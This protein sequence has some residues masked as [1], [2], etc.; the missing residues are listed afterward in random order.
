MP[1]LQL[2]PLLRSHFDALQ[3]RLACFCKYGC[4]L[5]GWFKGELLTVLDAALQAG[6]I[7]DVDREIATPAGKIDLRVTL[8]GEEPTW[9]ELKHWLIGVQRGTRYGAGFYFGDPTSVGITKDVKKLTDGERAGLGYVLVLM[10]AN[11]GNDEWRRGIEKFNRKFGPLRITSASSPSDFPAA[12]F[13]GVLR[14]A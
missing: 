8:P 14:V 5:E 10:T 4:Q 9:I 11:P 12:Y 6:T 3:D 2:L 13:L 1:I 7:V